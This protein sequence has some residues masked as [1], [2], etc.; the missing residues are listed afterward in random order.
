MLAIQSSESPID[1][2]NFQN[3]NNSV[4]IQ[5]KTFHPSAN[6]QSV[7]PPL[8]HEETLHPSAIN[9]AFQSLPCVQPSMIDSSL[10]PRTSSETFLP[11]APFH[12]V[13]TFQS[14][15][16]E[17]YQLQVT[18]HPEPTI[19]TAGTEPDRI[20][21]NGAAFHP[22]FNFHPYGSSYSESFQSPFRKN[23]TSASTS[24]HPSRTFQSTEIVSQPHGTSLP[25]VQPS[26]TQPQHVTTAKNTQ[27]K[28]TNNKKSDE[29]IKS[30]PLYKS[31][32]HQLEVCRGTNVSLSNKI[33]KL[34][35][36]VRIL[37]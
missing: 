20:F 34:E 17:N 14:P 18:S 16:S 15:H 37:Q 30:S 21:L 7:T 24:L 10:Q 3:R 9:L 23:A 32:T 35:E 36:T 19:P 29:E 6:V 8:R 5:Q 31:L 27:S 28:P 2:S 22:S 26:V 4:E 33:S 13:A 12:P 25:P 1:K 11:T